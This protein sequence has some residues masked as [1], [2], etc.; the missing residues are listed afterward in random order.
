MK[1]S[2]FEGFIVAWNYK[3]LKRLDA[4]AFGEIYIGIN[5]ENGSHIAI[6]VV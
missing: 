5:N 1:S 2:N 3:V 4:G 6:K